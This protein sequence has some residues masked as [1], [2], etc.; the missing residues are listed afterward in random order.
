[1]IFQR[2]DFP[3]LK[4]RPISFKGTLL[5]VVKVSTDQSSIFKANNLAMPYFSFFI[6]P[7]KVI[8]DNINIRFLASHWQSLFGIF[9]ALLV[10][11]VNVIIR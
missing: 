10:S 1:V 11:M 2:N 8:T 6:Q 3:I 7:F 9:T 5:P 4:K